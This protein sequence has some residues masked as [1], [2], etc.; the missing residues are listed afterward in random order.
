MQTDLE[1]RRRSD[2][3]RQAEEFEEMLDSLTADVSLPPSFMRG[4][5]QAKVSSRS[6]TS[7][8]ATAA[9]TI[10][11]AKWVSFHEAYH[12]EI[13]ARLYQH[14][15]PSSQPSRCTVLS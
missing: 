14:P 8:N 11:F 1:G 3:R 5:E 4:G 10:L 7:S 12:G 2:E 15:E 13:A 9:N 6:H